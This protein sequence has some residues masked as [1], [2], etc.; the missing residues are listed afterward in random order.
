MNT[1]RLS[2]REHRLQRTAASSWLEE[3]EDGGGAQPAAAESQCTNSSWTPS[4]CE[5]AI[6]SPQSPCRAPCGEVVAEGSRA[7][8]AEE[9]MHHEPAA[10]SCQLLLI[11][12]VNTETVRVR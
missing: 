11:P 1:N 2:H 6:S 12:P 5:V 9:F 8:A 7:A 3:L 10:P 4:S